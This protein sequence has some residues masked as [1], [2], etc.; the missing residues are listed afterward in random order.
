MACQFG[1]CLQRDYHFCNICEFLGE[2]IVL[3]NEKIHR[4]ALSKQA[5]LYIPGVII[6][7]LCIGTEVISTASY[8]G[9]SS[10][11]VSGQPTPPGQ[12]P[13]W[14]NWPIRDELCH[15]LGQKTTKTIKNYLWCSLL[16]A[17]AS[18]DAQS[19]IFLLYFVCSQTCAVF[20][21]SAGTCIS[22]IVWLSG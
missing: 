17:L 3:V 13:P 20:F 10:S 6:F 9:A 4:P 16:D 19:S 12:L 8:T 2:R 1:L 5:A 14:T 18:A 21:P 11:W 7:P 22:L 15:E